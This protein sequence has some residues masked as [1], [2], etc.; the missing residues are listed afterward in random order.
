MNYSIP[1][2]PLKFDLETK[3]ILKKLIEAKSALTKLDG[4][5]NIIPNKD[6]LINTLS[7][8][9]AKNSSSLENIITTD[10]DLF[11]S[12]SFDNPVS[13]VES[14]EVYRY[15]DALKKGY[16]LVKKNELLTNNYIKEIQQNLTKSNGDFR[17]ISGTNLTNDATGEI[18]YTP[19][20]NY[21][22]IIF[23]M[24]NLESFINDDT[25]CEFDSLIKMAIIH[26][27]FESIHPFP[28]GNGRTGRIINVLYLVKQNLLQTPVL[29]LSRYINEYKSEYYRLL[30][31]VREDFT[32]SSWENWILYL[33]TG[34]EETSLQ[35]ITLIENIK[36]LMQSHKDTMRKKLGKIYSQDLLNATFNYPY[37]TISILQ[38]ELS[39]SRDT[40]T[41]YLNKLCNINLAKKIKIGRENYY[42][43]KDLVNLLRNVNP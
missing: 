41:S 16:E 5:S 7:L 34:I 21:N 28:D 11:T 25:L 6:I 4:I 17:K 40:A 14:K 31:A 8:Q 15:A 12:Q 42:I 23:S 38:R 3:P 13:S 30:Q 24:T 27:Q 39:I 22:E 1:S 9:E 37:T 29:Y 10:E 20:Q 36:K 43:N 2:L 35:G 32:L 19:P 33:L 18:I 26:H